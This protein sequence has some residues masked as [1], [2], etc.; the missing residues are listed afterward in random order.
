MLLL[1]FCCFL[2]RFLF[3]CE[4]TYFVYWLIVYALV[5][6]ATYLSLHGLRRYLPLSGVM[7]GSRFRLAQIQIA[8]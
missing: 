6:F 8:F 2:H 1:H 3:F 4:R 7:H 5:D